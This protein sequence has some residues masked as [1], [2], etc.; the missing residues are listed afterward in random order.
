MLPLWA[1][2]AV[3]QT[4]CNACSEQQEGHHNQ[5]DD[6]LQQTG[7]LG[8]GKGR[9]IGS[10]RPECWCD[11]EGADRAWTYERGDFSRNKWQ[12]GVSELP[13]VI[14]FHINAQ[15]PAPK[16]LTLEV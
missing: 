5:R 13:C 16:S 7:G 14:P 12:D 4:P 1:V 11:V 9:D 6:C 2:E 8:G 3:Q 15:G 10:L